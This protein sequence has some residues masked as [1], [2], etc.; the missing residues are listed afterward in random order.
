M[1]VS[2]KPTCSP[3]TWVFC[4]RSSLRK[5]FV[6]LHAAAFDTEYAASTGA[7]IQLAT[8]STL[9]SAPPPFC[10]HRGEA[11]ADPHQAEQVGFEHALR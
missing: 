8:D 6:T 11:L 9:S 7:L 2:M 4:S 1:S 5:P 10:Q 3:S